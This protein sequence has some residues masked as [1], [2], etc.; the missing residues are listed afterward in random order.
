MPKNTYWTIMYSIRSIFWYYW[1]CNPLR[2]TAWTFWHFWYSFSIVQI[3]NFKQTAT[4]SHIWVTFIPTRSSFRRPAGVCPWPFS[5]LFIHNVNKS[6]NYYSRCQSSYARPVNS[7]GLAVSLTG[8]YTFYSPTAVA[9]VAHGF[10][11]APR[12]Y[13]HNDSCQ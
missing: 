9:T 6:N 3:I 13:F 1:S 11:L 10:I 2:T 12:F 4:R 7:H 5:V 8:F